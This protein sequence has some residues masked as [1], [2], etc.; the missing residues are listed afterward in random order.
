M[1]A[2][3]LLAVIGVGLLL[4]ARAWAAEPSE[5]GELVRRLIEL[6]VQDQAGAMRLLREH[7]ELLAAR[8]LHD[9]TPLHYCAVEGLTEGVRF[10]AGAGVPVDAENQFGDTALVDAVTLGNVEI[11][12][13]LLRHGANPDAA[14]RTKG[15]VLHIAAGQG[16]AGLVSALLDAG[17]RADYVTDRGE[18]VWDAVPKAGPGLDQVLRV[19]ER[20]GVRR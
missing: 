12:K 15:R 2:A 13:V 3:L 16:N 7:P 20:H 11:V 9:E 17:A 18:T 14:S 5:D 6:S 8:Y 4:F 19:L 10:L 1:L